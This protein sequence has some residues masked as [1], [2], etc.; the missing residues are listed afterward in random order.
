MLIAALALPFALTMPAT[1]AQDAG[2]WRS[3][4]TLYEKVC[5]HCHAPE[6]GVGTV[7]AGR[8][9]PAAYISVIVRNGFNGMPA[10]PASFIDDESI[11]RVAE[12]LATLPAPA[13]QP[14]A[15]QPAANR[16]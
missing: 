16:P 14:A 4:K 15:N 8:N 11:V 12:Y 7:L 10:F 2:Q 13:A 5:G 6:V 9:L 1:Q 3:G